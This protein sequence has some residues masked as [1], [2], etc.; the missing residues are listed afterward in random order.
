MP[1]RPSSTGTAKNGLPGTPGP[2]SPP[3]IEPTEPTQ[4]LPPKAD[5]EGPETVSPTGQA[6]GAEQARVAQSG[7]YLTTAQGARL[8]DTDHS[9]KA[10]AR[11]PV[12]LQDHHLREKIMHFDHER[13][14]E[15]VVHAR[16]AAAHGVFQSYGT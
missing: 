8:Y 4:P 15:R 3:L 10:G 2:E 7:T 12:L 5:Q 14:P 16:G 9:L 1:K 11:G 6:T 13:I